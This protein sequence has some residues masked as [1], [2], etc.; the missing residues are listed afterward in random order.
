M[1]K[2]A[3]TKTA[4][5]G[6][7]AGLTDFENVKFADLEKFGAKSV[8]VKRPWWRTVRGQEQ[9]KT[10]QRGRPAGSGGGYR[11]SFKDLA[12][13]AGPALQVPVSRNWLKEQKDSK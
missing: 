6:R 10:G 13:I 3:K 8:L 7:P 2:T 4:Q 9:N 12:K 1:S 5:R 11:V